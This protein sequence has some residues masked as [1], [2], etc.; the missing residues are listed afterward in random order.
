M[1]VLDIP[2]HY[3]LRNYVPFLIVFNF[4]LPEPTLDSLPPVLYSIAHVY[5]A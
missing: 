5:S 1:L 2:T 3:V 4:P